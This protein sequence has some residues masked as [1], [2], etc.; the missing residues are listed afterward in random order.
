MNKKEIRKKYLK[1]REE[2][3]E[4]EKKAAN[5]VICDTLAE[6]KPL[7][8]SSIIGAYI[9]DGD[10]PDLRRFL[11]NVVKESGC[12]LLLPRFNK[13]THAYEMVA[14]PSVDDS[15]LEVGQYGILEPKQ[16]FEAV[17]MDIYPTITWFI[18]GVA[19]SNTGKRLGRGKGIYDRFLAVAKGYR[20]G[21]FYDCQ[22]C[23]VI[24]MEAHD[25]LL[26]YVIT[27]K[28]VIEVEN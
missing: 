2:L 18:P 23:D 8:C 16:E 21:V 22:E 26:D 5:R 9:S 14:V 28:R 11:E 15:V 4:E 19:F 24:P 27:E 1:L 25:Q 10:E 20:I 6:F 13:S 3:K 17:N 12:V 7:K